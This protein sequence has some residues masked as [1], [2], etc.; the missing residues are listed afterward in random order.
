MDYLKITYRPTAELDAIARQLE[1]V[2]SGEIRRLIITMPPRSMKSIAASV[3]F[4]AYL[5]GHDPRQQIVAVSY[6]DILA[7]KLALDCL[8]VMEAPWYQEIFPVA[9]CRFCGH[10]VR[11]A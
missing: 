1:R 2:A 8:R 7:E 3:A 5:L 11:F 6:S 9:C 4:P 10:R